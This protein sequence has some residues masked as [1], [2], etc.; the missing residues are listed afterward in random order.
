MELGHIFIPKRSRV[1]TLTE[2]LAGKYSKQLTHLPVALKPQLIEWIVMRMC[3]FIS[4][5][6]IWRFDDTEYTAETRRKVRL[7]GGHGR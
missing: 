1:S 3:V 2:S 4:L 7:C 6:Y 5:E